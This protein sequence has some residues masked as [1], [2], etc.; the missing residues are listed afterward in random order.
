MQPLTYI[1]KPLRLPDEAPTSP[2]ICETVVATG[3]DLATNT[4][5]EVEVSG[6]KESMMVGSDGLLFL[7]TATSNP[8]APSELGESE[9]LVVGFSAKN[10]S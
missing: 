3:P 2:L 8:K 10:I 7:G 9:D 6:K 5:I 4:S 1:L